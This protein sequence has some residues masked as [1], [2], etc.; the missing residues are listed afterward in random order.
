MTA[1]PPGQSYTASER[2]VALHRTFVANVDARMRELG[3]IVTRQGVGFGKPD[4]NRLADASGI[5]KRTVENLMRGGNQPSMVGAAAIARALGRPLDTLLGMDPTW[6]YGEAPNGSA[7]LEC[8]D[9]PRHLPGMRVCQ[10]CL[11]KWNDF[12]TRKRELYEKSRVRAA[13]EADTRNE[14]RKAT[15]VATGQ[16]PEDVKR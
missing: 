7:V 4:L 1:P 13:V 16:D 3:W 14:E 11:D 10:S 6:G 8:I 9:T 5:P 12:Q 2:A 15:V